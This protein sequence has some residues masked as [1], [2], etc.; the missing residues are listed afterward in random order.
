MRV[1]DT[2]TMCGGT[3]PAAQCR[4]PTP[5]G[6]YDDLGATDFHSPNFLLGVPVMVATQSTLYRFGLIVRDDAVGKHVQLALY[7][8]NGGGNTAL[9]AQTNGTALLGGRNEI[10][11]TV[12]SVTLAPGAYWIMAVFDQTTNVAHDVS[13]SATWRFASLA[14]GSALPSTIGATTSQVGVANVN[15]YVLVF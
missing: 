9:V 14:Y 3:Y 6:W 12:S 4:L 5:I 15:F 13:T 10:S 2:G 8:D 7:R 1:C 11:P